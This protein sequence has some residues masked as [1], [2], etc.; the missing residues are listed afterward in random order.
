MQKPNWN[1]ISYFQIFFK[2]TNQYIPIQCMRFVTTL[3]F[4]QYLTLYRFLYLY[5]DTI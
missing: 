4:I 1:N 3:L 2:V 5:G